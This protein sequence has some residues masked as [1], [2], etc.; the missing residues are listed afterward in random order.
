[1]TEN[2]DREWLLSKLK[3]LKK[4]H[5]LLSQIIDTLPTRRDWLDPSLEAEMKDFVKREG[6]T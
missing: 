2:I 5:V 3:A 1:M 4:A 6:K